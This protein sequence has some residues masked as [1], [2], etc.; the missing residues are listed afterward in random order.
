MKHLDFYVDKPNGTHKI[1]PAS[2]ND[3]Q[4]IYVNER[5]VRITFVNGTMVQ[6]PI[7]DTTVKIY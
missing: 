1:G 2:L 5:F 7:K 6:R 3:I 4:E